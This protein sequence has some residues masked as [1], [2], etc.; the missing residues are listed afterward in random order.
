MEE[1]LRRI[2]TLENKVN[3]LMQNEEYFNNINKAI[4]QELNN[5]NKTSTII[6][7]ILN[8]KH[9]SNNDNIIT[10]INLYKQ[11]QNH[12]LNV[13]TFILELLDERL[14]VGCDDG[15]I[16]LNQINYETKK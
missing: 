13:V 16:S 11:T 15:T 12:H 5:I 10:S 14:V 1:V 9:R 6:L 7:N 4:I 3:Y 8:S 2:T